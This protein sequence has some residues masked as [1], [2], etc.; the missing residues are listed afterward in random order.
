MRHQ[1]H[2]LAVGTHYGQ[3]WIYGPGLRSMPSEGLRSRHSRA[4]QQ[5][6][7]KQGLDTTSDDYG[8]A[9]SCQ[10]LDL[11]TAAG[12]RATRMSLLWAGWSSWRTWA[13]VTPRYRTDDYATAGSGPTRQSGTTGLGVCCKPV[14]A[15]CAGLLL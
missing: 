13:G 11:A 5:Q 12:A 1:E 10:R 6:L 15:A 7:Q 9:T 2:M 8:Q 4:S 3:T 14:D